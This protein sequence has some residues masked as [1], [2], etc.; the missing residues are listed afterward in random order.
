M[1]KDA[2]ALFRFVTLDKY[3]RPAEATAE[4]ARTG[5]KALWNRIRH[6]KTTS[7][8]IDIHAELRSISQEMLD[9]VS[10]AP[11]WEEA[12]ESLLS[13][14]Q[15]WINNEEPE[16][17]VQV[18][19]G[20]PGTGIRQVL[21]TIATEKQW[22]IIN[23]P[24]F[25]QILKKDK[26]WLDQFNKEEKDILVLPVMERCYLRHY[27]GLNLI[28][29][30]LDILWEKRI[31]CLIGC[32]SWAWSYFCSAIKIDNIL[33]LPLTMQAFDAIHLGYWFQKLA[34]NTRS[35]SLVFRQSDNGNIILS[36]S[37]DEKLVNLLKENK[38]SV[39]DADKELPV[40]L[41]RLATRSFGIPLIAWAIWRNSLQIA[42]DEVIE[43][44]ALKA[45]AIDKGLTIWVKPWSKLDLP[46]IQSNIGKS[47]FM[48]LHTIL[49]HG[50]LPESFI[51]YLLPYSSTEITKNLLL[52]NKQGL[53][54][55]ENG[56][57]RTTLLGYPAIR[58]Y[59]NNEGY[60]VDAF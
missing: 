32:N 57:W 6:S 41:K 31:K 29:K 39:N 27:N 18:V 5:L 10:P 17:S 36:L 51:N 4:A 26:K 53:I 19:V 48:V 15:E 54:K 23:P 59:L 42:G 58:Q 16:Q 38:E 8:P 45:A 52:L 24:T 55:E 35:R 11:T 33:P 22:K 49:L 25:R 21:T 34:L 7:E 43:Y 47:E 3:I 30:L 20:P 14:I 50:G 9:W 2:V 28:R 40:F 46:D 44:D 1:D 37:D 60:L 12:K 13:S 56:L